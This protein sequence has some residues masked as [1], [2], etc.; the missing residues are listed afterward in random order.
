MTRNSANLANVIT[1]SF[2]VKT[3]TLGA[4]SILS[5]RYSNDLRFNYTS[6][7]GRAVYSLDN[8]GGAQ[9]IDPSQ[10]FSVPLPPSYDFGAVL[11]FGTNPGLNVSP[12][13]TK[14]RQL[15]LV[16]SISASYGSH[17]VKFGMDFRRLSTFVYGNQL[18]DAFYFFSAADVLANSA[19]LAFVQTFDLTEPVFSNYSVYFQDEWRATNRLHLSLGLRWELNPPPGNGAGVAR[20]RSIR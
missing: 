15:N 20:T 13:R 3:L 7:S 2:D 17:L 12:F 18:Q 9:A 10:L 4:T 8:F 5:P 6:N 11:F 14:Q 16:D 19:S 1:Q